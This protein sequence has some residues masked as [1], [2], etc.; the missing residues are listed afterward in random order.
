ML[1]KFKPKLATLLNRLAR[2]L[3]TDDHGK[4]PGFY[5]QQDSCQIPH[6]WLL[7]SR[8]L[9]DRT[10]G[11]F[12]EVGGFDGVSWSN[13]WGLAAKGWRGLIVEPVPDLAA[14]CERNHEA[15]QGVQVF[16]QAIAA[17]GERSIELH[18][19]GALTTANPNQREEY[20]RQDWSRPVLTNDRV[21]VPACS[22]DE[23]LDREGVPTGFDVLIVDVEGFESAVFDGFDISRWRPSMMIVELADTHMSLSSTMR[24]DALLGQ[25]IVAA[26]YEIVAKDQVNTVFVEKRIWRRAFGV[27]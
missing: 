6:L 27:E 12:V 10:D 4:T 3:G 11:C 7:L 17:P 9:G 23:F 13:S 5:P 19:G 22:L 26:G 1:K 21:V 2:R 15:H 25:Q 14:T 18:L 20:S 24:S 8:F 16:Q